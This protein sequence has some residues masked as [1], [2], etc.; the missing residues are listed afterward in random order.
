MKL[1]LIYILNYM[2]LYLLNIKLK[3]TFW[4]VESISE[5]YAFKVDTTFL[6][7]AYT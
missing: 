3:D 1:M 5:P 4:I 6:A 7:E 2:S